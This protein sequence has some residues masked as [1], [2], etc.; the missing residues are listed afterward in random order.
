VKRQAA[1]LAELQTLQAAAQFR[2]AQAAAA[3]ARS[4]VEQASDDLDSRVKHGLPIET[5]QAAGAEIERLLDECVRRDAAVSAAGAAYRAALE[6]RRRIEAEIDML[7]E[8]LARRLAVLRKQDEQQR[9]QTADDWTLR[10]WSGI[11][12]QGS[13]P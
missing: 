10:Q 8:L 12:T 6:H 1:R 2:R 9:Q 11:K 7:E 13:E 4:D 5:L 3:A